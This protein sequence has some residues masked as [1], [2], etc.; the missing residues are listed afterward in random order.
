MDDNL[1]SVVAMT[2]SAI[3][4]GVIG[5]VAQ[6]FLK[7]G[8]PRVHV[9][10]SELSSV[11]LSQVDYMEVPSEIAEKMRAMN[12]DIFGDTNHLPNEGHIFPIGALKHGYYFL[13]EFRHVVD[14]AQTSAEEVV[15]NIPA[16]NPIELRESIQR[17]LH[18]MLILQTLMGMTRRGEFSVFKDGNV[19]AEAGEKITKLLNDENTE[20]EF[21]W[22]YSGQP[23]PEEGFA[24]RFFVN[25]DDAHIS[26]PFRLSNER[27]RM[28]VISY[29]FAS[30]N[31]TEIQ[32]ILNELST[33]LARNRNLANDIFFWMRENVDRHST[34]VM[35]TTI[36]NIGGR[37]LLFSGKGYIEGVLPNGEKLKLECVSEGYSDNSDESNI[38]RRLKVFQNIGR[39]L[40]IA[41]PVRRY[42]T[43]EKMLVEG[44]DQVAV[45]FRS[46]DTLDE[47][48]GGARLLEQFIAGELKMRLVVEN[49]TENKINR[50]QSDE[51]VFAPSVNENE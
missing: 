12:F 8:D 35:N 47:I 30:L 48:N 27:M 40:D 13:K 4:G 7:R 46:R 15:R 45:V 5:A 50:V 44:G 24:G 33:S 17:L 32:G 29:L 1:V 31:K 25:L 41:I 42:I 22:S 21:E 51:F 28:G 20:T 37:P 49:I 36:S 18:E 14:R 2:G 10:S 3:C 23:I 26:F 9:I 6:K 11:L 19:I 38:R 43:T 39:G 16:M 34:F